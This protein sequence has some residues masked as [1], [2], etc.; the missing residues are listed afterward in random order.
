M[1]DKE[2][3]FIFVTPGKT[4]LY[5]PI[6]CQYCKLDEFRC[7]VVIFRNEDMEIWKQNG[8]MI[9]VNPPDFHD[10]VYH[11]EYPNEQIRDFFGGRFPYSPKQYIEIIQNNK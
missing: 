7:V 5:E 8:M 1:Q 10:M 2:E 6:H 11:N 9:I 3:E 4:G